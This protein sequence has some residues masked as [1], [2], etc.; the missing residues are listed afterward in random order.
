VWSNPIAQPLAV[1]RR[2]LTVPVA[3]SQWSSVLGKVGN[4]DGVARAG[5]ES[6]VRNV[7]SLGL[8]FGGGCF[9]GHGVNVQGGTARFVLVNY[10]I[11]E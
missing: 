4:V 3:P 8:T 1:G 5:F 10:E 9:F 7:S 6:A 11:R 2:T